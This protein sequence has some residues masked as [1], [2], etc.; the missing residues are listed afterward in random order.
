MSYKNK[1]KVDLFVATLLLFSFF[2]VLGFFLI[3]AKNEGNF[4]HNKI[5][6]FVAENISY[7]FP[8]VFLGSTF[9]KFS[10][11]FL[12]IL[13]S[14]NILLYSTIAVTLFVNKVNRSQRYKPFDVIHFIAYAIPSIF[15]TIFIIGLFEN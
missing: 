2:A 1:I 7:L 12:I 10:L 5:L 3:F 11:L 9:L 6:F 8:I 13:T 15:I 14:L 4:D